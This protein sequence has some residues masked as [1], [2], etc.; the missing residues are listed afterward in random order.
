MVL[1][2]NDRAQDLILERKHKQ[3]Q[4]KQQQEDPIPTI[5]EVLE[6]FIRMQISIV[7]MSA[8]KKFYDTGFKEPLDTTSWCLPIMY[9]LMIKQFELALTAEGFRRKLKKLERYGFIKKIPHTNPSIYEPVVR[10]RHVIRRAI[11]FWLI[12]RGYRSI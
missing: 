10:H 5:D 3:V 1:S 2:S 8:L 12:K 7:D 11:V 9:K 4:H 6:K